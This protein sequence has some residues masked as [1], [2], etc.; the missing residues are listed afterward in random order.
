MQKG[1]TNKMLD[2]T[3]NGIS[4]R[5]YLDKDPLM[6][7]TALSKMNLPWFA[8]PGFSDPIETPAWAI[9]FVKKICDDMGIIVPNHIFFRVSEHTN[10]LTFISK[11]DNPEQQADDSIFVILPREEVNNERLAR[12]V[13]LHEVAHYIRIRKEA[14]GYPSYWAGGYCD[15]GQGFYETFSP[16]VN[17]YCSDPEFA[18]EIWTMEKY[19]RRREIRISRRWG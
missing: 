8:A 13:L 4:V 17:R 9:E 3:I 11:I 1:I 19:N 16:L 10:G 18:R 14:P 15:H 6:R 12:Q 2:S 7:F 5:D